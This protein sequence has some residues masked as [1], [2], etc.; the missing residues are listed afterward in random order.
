MNRWNVFWSGE[1]EMQPAPLAKQSLPAGAGG[2]VFCTQQTPWNVPG[3]QEL[4]H[5]RAEL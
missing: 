5:D 2:Q 1:T 4:S 3:A